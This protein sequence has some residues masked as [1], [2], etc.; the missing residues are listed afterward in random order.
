MLEGAVMP[1]ADDNVGEGGFD[2]GEARDGDG[3]EFTMEGCLWAGLT[4]AEYNL[5]VLDE[6]SRSTVEG[7]GKILVNQRTGLAVPK[8]WRVVAEV[9]SEHQR[10]DPWFEFGVDYELGR[11]GTYRVIESFPRFRK[12]V[13]VYIG[14]DLGGRAQRSLSEAIGCYLLQFDV[15][16]IVFCRAA[17]E[18]LLKDTLAE[19]GHT[20]YQD[21]AS[22]PTAGKVINDAWSAGVL[23]ESVTAARRLKRTADFALHRAVPDEKILPQQALDSINDLAAVLAEVLGAADE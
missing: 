19:A 11:A 16:C 5:E 17:T 4:Y 22:A 15:A 3:P 18:A 12:V 1:D 14:R 10:K 23:R 20:Q 6:Q 13:P 9:L 2:N 21:V 7:V 8:E